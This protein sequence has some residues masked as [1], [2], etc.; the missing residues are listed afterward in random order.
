MN[1]ITTTAKEEMIRKI[2]CGAQG[3]QVLGKQEIREIM[4]A[5]MNKPL[6]EIDNVLVDKCS[7]LLCSQ[8]E[9]EES[10]NP[11]ETT[12]AESKR[13]LR[14]RIESKEF[15]LNW[16]AIFSRKYIL[17]TV[18]A[19]VASIIVIGIIGILTGRGTLKMQTSEDGGDHI[20]YGETFAADTL[21]IAN[22]DRM[23]NND[24]DIT[25]NLGD[26]FAHLGYEIDM[27]MNLP[28]DVILSEVDVMQDEVS[29]SLQC[30][31]NISGE[32]VLQFDID[33]IHDY[34]GVTIAR[35]QNQNGERIA[36]PSGKIVYT[37]QNFERNWALYTVGRTVYQ[38][39][40]NYYDLT[41][42]LWIIDSIG[43]E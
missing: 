20:T 10:A 8:Y 38:I 33:I 23:T 35:E 24:I 17:R 32:R 16:S 30:V 22:A 28:E 37:A 31:Y 9:C 1:E 42:I 26:A 2:W 4:D 36:L 25:N 14:A 19:T 3:E 11:S 13:S 41:T 29:D 43:E 39:T 34:A 5:E 6:N 21:Q 27:P 18:A 7:Q 12:I 40:S 15:N